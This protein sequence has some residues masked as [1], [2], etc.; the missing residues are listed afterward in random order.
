M[1]PNATIRL[2]A[3]TAMLAVGAGIVA[4]ATAS[5]ATVVPPPSIP[6]ITTAPDWTPPSIATTTIPTSAF[7]SA[8]EVDAAWSTLPSTSTAIN[9]KKAVAGIVNHHVLAAPLIAQFFND[10]RAARPDLKRLILISPDHHPGT[11]EATIITEPYATPDGIQDIDE[12]ALTSLLASG[13]YTKDEGAVAAQEH[14]IGVL[15]PFIRRAFGDGLRIVPVVIRQTIDPN[16]A[17][18]IAHDLAGL[19]DDQTAVILSAD[20]S[21][22]LNALDASRKDIETIVWLSGL[23]ATSTQSAGDLNLD[24]GLNASILFTMMREKGILPAFNVFAH[25]DS[26]LF[27]GNPSSVTSYVTVAW[28]VRQ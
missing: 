21:H 12:G 6:T 20:L 5:R 15:V 10:L 13:L 23:D 22:G 14:G 27:G 11:P 2:I 24:S 18:A 17:K 8:S 16:H 19:W 7:I 1:T 3:T 25:R 4:G 28:T 9:K 26:T